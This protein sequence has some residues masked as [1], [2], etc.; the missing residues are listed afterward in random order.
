MA[1][2]VFLEALEDPLQPA[3]VLV[4]LPQVIVEGLAQVGRRSRFRHLRQSLDELRLGAV[5]VFQLFEVEILEG[6]QF[7]RILLM[8]TPG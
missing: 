2:G 8:F 7:H 5:E 3:H 6:F 1:L 4:G